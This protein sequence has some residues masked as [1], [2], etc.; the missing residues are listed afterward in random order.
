MLEKTLVALS[1]QRLRMLM[2]GKWLVCTSGM[3]WRKHLLHR[4]VALLRSC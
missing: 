2:H 4:I 3:L 1:F